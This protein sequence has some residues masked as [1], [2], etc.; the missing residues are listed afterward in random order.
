MG[1][2]S[3][4]SELIRQAADALQL[5]DMHLH[6]LCLT[7][8]AISDRKVREQEILGLLREQ[9]KFSRLVGALIALSNKPDSVLLQEALVKI[10]SDVGP[11][12]E[13]TKDVQWNLSIAKEKVEEIRVAGT[14]PLPEDSGKGAGIKITVSTDR[15]EYE[16]G[17]EITIKGKVQTSDPAQPTMI[18]VY[19]PSGKAYRFD[20][21]KLAKDGSFEYRLNVGGVLGITG[22]YITRVTHGGASATTEFKFTVNPER[23]RE[24][25]SMSV[26][27]GNSKKELR[28]VS[29][30]A[31]VKDA[32]GDQVTAT[33]TIQISSEAHGKLIL[34]L[35]RT[36]FDSKESDNDKDLDFIVFV[37]ELE[38]FSQDSRHGNRRILEITFEKGSKVIDIVGTRMAG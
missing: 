21:V 9:K 25:K 12:V 2:L 26:R 37:D 23:I 16:T 4:K 1:K 27:I 20:Q 6:N 38:A 35:P 31:Y 33:L 28:Y 36:V 3:T 34:E 19:A 18:S 30:G 32:T 14:R 11:A 10:L 24:W 13:E 22:I 29:D 15:R 17:D 7:I 8:R 5:M